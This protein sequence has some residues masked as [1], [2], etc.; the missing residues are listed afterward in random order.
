MS[1][2]SSGGSGSGT[3]LT[4]GAITQTAHGF[5]VG[6]IIGFDG[7]AYVKAQANNSVNAEATGIVTSVINANSFTFSQ[8]GLITGLSGLTP[9]EVYYL[10]DSVAGT[11]TT[12]EPTAVTSVSKPLLEA[13][14]ATSGYYTNFRGTPA[15]GQTAVIQYGENNTITSGQTIAG[16]SGFVNITNGS[17]TLP[18]AGTW[19]VTYNVFAQSSSAGFRSR[20]QLVKNSDN[21]VVPNSYATVVYA[22]GNYIQESTQTVTIITTASEVYKLQALADNGTVTVFNSSS[23]GNSKITWTQIGASPVPMDLAGEYVAPQYA[24]AN[25]SPTAAQTSSA[26][27]AQ[28]MSITIPTAGTWNIEYLVRGYVGQGASTASAISAGLYDSLGALLPNSE[29]LSTNNSSSATF[30][31][32][33]SGTRTY[34]VTTTGPTTYNVKVWN[35]QATTLGSAT[36]DASGRSYIRANKI[37]GF[38]PSSGQS[39]DYAGVEQHSVG[40]ATNLFGIT[41]T[42]TTTSG[43]LLSTTSR[44]NLT[45]ATVI[46]NLIVNNA[47]GTIAIV[48]DGT[49][50][51][52]ITINTQSAGAA[53]QWGQLIK[54]NATVINVASSYNQTGSAILQLV[55]NYTGNFVAGDLIDVRLSA[56][57]A[58][59]IG[60]TGYSYN[61]HQL[62]SSNV[63]A[64]LYPGTWGTY[65]PTITAVT[66]NPTKPSSGIVIDTASYLVEGKK[67]TVN[68]NFWIGTAVAPGAGSGTYKFSLPPGIVIDTTKVT[69]IASVEPTLSNP[70]IANILGTVEMNRG[71]QVSLTTK[72]LGHVYAADANNFTAA[73]MISAY[74]TLSM[75]DSNT[76]N[77]GLQ[78]G[79]GWKMQ[80]TVPIV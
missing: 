76:G 42:N 36:S 19:E 7:T 34:T 26:N 20:F 1:L 40:N 35:F 38:L 32:I 66:T 74:S 12:I 52:G 25:V 61:V 30:A 4:S 17:F 13:V 65:V 80:F 27:A 23:E 68:Y 5:V 73:A 43:T 57:S 44:V 62:G 58:G 78:S 60:V 69:T 8:S 77:A 70:N 10:S 21:S 31:L 56:N 50:N 55:L 71:S 72:L 45:G 15:Q 75:F 16:G 46:G 51:I 64:G 54:N 79:I 28:F 33:T 14:S 18:S 37:S 6:N 48:K 67:L 63:I 41:S 53:G 39:V 11:L 9:G 59:T 2:P 29:L 24:A 47:N 3:T 49:Y 22:A